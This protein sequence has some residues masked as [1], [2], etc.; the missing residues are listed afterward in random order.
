MAPLIKTFTYTSIVLLAMLSSRP[1]F[2]QSQCQS[3]FQTKVPSKSP[4]HDWQPESLTDLFVSLK[5][6]NLKKN[7]LQ[8]SSQGEL[9]DVALDGTQQLIG[10]LKI[11]KA[12]YLFNW[13]SKEEH[14]D[15]IHDK[16]ITKDYMNTIL[17]A[18]GQ[19]AGKGF[20]I[21]TDPFNSKNYGSDLTAY[22][23]HRDIVVLEYDGSRSQQVK[24]DAAFVKRLR[25]AGIDALRFKN[26]QAH[27]YAFI[28]TKHLQQAQP[29]PNDL[30]KSYLISKNYSLDSQIEV[31]DR[32]DVIPLGSIAS[33]PENI[34][35]KTMTQGQLGLKNL[36]DLLKMT[37]GASYYARSKINDLILEVA[38][39]LFLRAPTAEEA[40][41]LLN[42]MMKN[43]P[44]YEVANSINQAKVK[45]TTAKL[46][47]NYTIINNFDLSTIA[48]LAESRSKPDRVN[49][50]KMKDSAKKIENA[51]KTTDLT[52]ISSLQDFL[53]AAETIYGFR[54][55]F[56][57]TSAY[58]TNNKENSKQSLQLDA[59]VF[60]N[61]KTNDLLTVKVTKDSPALPGQVSSYVQYWNLEKFEQI[62]PLV[63]AET[64]NK[65]YAAL[66]PG[67]NRSEGS[68]I[69]Q[70]LYQVVLAEAT[71]S[72]F[73]INKM[74]YIQLCNSQGRAFDLY[75]IF[76][77]LHP[78][79]EGNERLA[80]LYYKMLID[81][82]PHLA[83]GYTGQ[84]T[85]LVSSNLD[86]LFESSSLSTVSE[87]QVVGSIL[88]LWAA[89]AKT[90]AELIN[91]SKWAMELFFRMYPRWRGQFP[92][93]SYINDN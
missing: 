57:T 81:K 49:L 79:K 86:L 92:E 69:D 65:V 39:Q 47:S 53:H 10:R 2:S 8:L 7:Q 54:P 31:L 50:T 91:R 67:S 30:L 83:N 89:Q 20:Y 29:F 26:Y 34:F 32:L 46:E 4:S 56:R 61:L 78:F 93:I 13:S 36:T 28:S 23:T 66:G 70:K 88:K 42:L 3:L 15:I 35:L 75:R 44:I 25:Q 74:R 18:P 80:R 5:T 12:K 14:L 45:I 76:L 16:G 58:M 85:D 52:V 33:L 37:K 90:D 60:K 55:E 22:P 41:Q 62:T 9:F 27:W 51:L 48:A 64:K 43:T 11:L 73:D 63:S 19:I 38:P 6:L 82:V 77:S 84:V 68:V 71:A 59:N 72:L 21:S 24:N 40:L 17:D 1:A 87:Y